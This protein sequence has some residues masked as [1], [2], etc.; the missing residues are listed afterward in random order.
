VAAIAAG[1]EWEAIAPLLDMF[2]TPGHPIAHPLPF[3]DGKKLVA[4]LG[5]PRGPIIGELL[6]ELA[7]ARA[8]GKVAT[9]A[10]A[11]EWARGLIG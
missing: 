7:I 5:L 9:E 8:E 3:V 1:V 11:I 10:E 6:T 2:R 4:A